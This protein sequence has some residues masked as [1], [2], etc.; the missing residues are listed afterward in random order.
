MKNKIIFSVGKKAVW[1]SIILVL[2]CAMVLGCAIFSAK[3]NCADAYTLSYLESGSVNRIGNL[4]NSEDKVFNRIALNQLAQSVGYSDVKEML[5]AVTESET[6]AKS[7]GIK[8]AADFGDTTVK[9]GSFNSLRDGSEIELEW[10]PVFLSQSNVDADKDGSDD[11]ILT[12]WLTNTATNNYGAGSNPGD[13]YQESSIYNYTYSYVYKNLVSYHGHP[14]VYAAG[15]SYAASYIRNYILN[16]GNSYGT[17]PNDYTMKPPTYSRDQ[18]CKFTMLTSG[19]LSSYIV[20]PSQVTWQLAENTV[21]NDYSYKYTNASAGG[22]IHTFF[23]TD[24]IE[25][26]IWLPSVAEVSVKTTAKYNLWQVNEN[27]RLGGNTPINIHAWLRSAYIPNYNTSYTSCYTTSGNYAFFY[28]NSLCVR[29]ALHLN[30]TAA[31]ANAASLVDKPEDVSVEYTGEKQDLSTLPELPDWAK[32]NKIE[33]DYLGQSIIDAKSYSI[34]ASITQDALDAAN[35][36]GDILKFRGSPDEEKGEDNY[37]RFFNFVVTKK[38]IELNLSLDDNRRPKIDFDTGQIFSGDT[39]ENTRA[40]IIKLRYSSQDATQDY[41]ENAPTAVGKYTA[42]AYVENDG[43]NYELKQE[44]TIDFEIKPKDVVKPTLETVEQVYDGDWLEFTLSG[45]SDDVVITAVRNTATSQTDGDPVI[46][47]ATVKAKRTGTY[48]ITVALADDGEASQWAGTTSKESYTIVFTVTPK[49]LN[50]SFESSI[51]AWSWENGKGGN[52]TVTEDSLSSDDVSLS[53]HYYLSTNPSNKITVSS[54]FDTSSLGIGVYYICAT[55]DSS[56]GNNANY[57]LTGNLVS[58]EFKVTEVNADISA[59]TWYYRQGDIQ[60]PATATNGIVHVTYTGEEYN[61]FVDDADFATQGVKIDTAFGASGYQNVKGINAMTSSRTATVRIV[62]LPG[63]K[64]SSGTYREFTLV[65]QIDK[66]DYDLSEVSWSAKE[67][68]YNGKSQTVTLVGLPTGLSVSRYIYSPSSTVGVG[69]YTASVGSFANAN[70]NYNTPSVD[71]FQS[72]NWSIVPIK[73]YISWD[74]DKNSDGEGSVYFVPVLHT[75]NDKVEYTYY[76]DANGKPSD[77]QISLADIVVDET[78]Q[79][80]YWVKVELKSA[81]SNFYQLVDDTGN[82]PQYY[83]TFPVGD[84]KTPVSVSLKSS[85]VTYN[86]AQQPVS[87]IISNIMIQESDFDIEYSS[88]S[89]NTFVATAPSNAGSYIVRI[90]LNQ[91]DY[92]LKGQKQ[93]NYQIDKADFDLSSVVWVYSGTDGSSGDYDEPFKYNKVTYTLTLSGLPSGVSVPSGAYGGNSGVDSKVYTASVS[94]L[95]YDK[96]NFNIIDL[97]QLDL[98]WEIEKMQITVIWTEK[99]ETSGSN[100]FEVWT[101]ES[102]QDYISAYYRWEQWD[103]SAPVAGATALTYDQVVASFDEAVSAKFVCYVLLK[104]SDNYAVSGLSFKEFEI[105]GNKTAVTV[106]LEVTDK[107]YDGLAFEPSVSTKIQ[108]G[109]EIYAQFEFA[110]YDENGD[111]LDCVPVNAGRYSVHITLTGSYAEDYVISG[112]SA[113][114]FTI[115]KAQ[116]DISDL[117]WSDGVNEYLFDET[118][119]FIYSGDTYALS[120]VGTS[121]IKDFEVTLSGDTNGKSARSYEIIIDVKENPNYEDC[122]LSDRFVWTIAPLAVDFAGTEWNYDSPFI[123]ARNADGAIEQNVGLTFPQGLPQEILD[124]LTALNLYG[125][126]YYATEVGRYEATANLTVLNTYVENG[127]D[128]NN[129][130]IAWADIGKLTWSIDS[131]DFDMPV[132]DGSWTVFDGD[133]H[134]L[135]VACGLPEG[136]QYYLDISVNIT[137]PD[138]A[139]QEYAGVD[140]IEWLGYDAGGYE[141]IFKVKDGINVNN[142][143]NVWIGDD[144]T[145]SVL[146]SVSQRVVTVSGWRGVGT[147]AQAQFSDE[148]VLSQW[149]TYV[150]Y[151][152][153]SQV[154]VVDPSTG[155]FAPGKYTRTVEPTS[156]NIKIQ[157][158]G[159]HAVTFTVDESGEETGG[160]L[161]PTPDDKPQITLDWDTSKNPP[162]LK[163]PDEYKDDLHPEYEYFDKDGNVIKLEDMVGGETYTVKAKLPADELDKF[164]IVDKNG[165]SVDFEELETIKF[166]KSPASIITPPPSSSSSLDEIIEKLKELP[167]WQLIASIISII[168]III[169]LSKTSGYESKRKKYNKKSDKLE[170]IYAVAPFLG[171][172]MSGWTAIACTLMGLA[173]AS[174]VIMLIVKIRC[175]KAEESYEDCLADFER[176]KKDEEK[177]SMRMMFMGM[178]GMSGGNIAYGIHDEL[179]QKL[180]EKTANNEETISQIV[181]NLEELIA[182]FLERDEIQQVAAAHIV[183]KVVEVPVEVEKIVEKEVPVEVE[184]IIEKEVRVEVPVEKVVEK[185]V[186][187]EVKVEA[188]AP[189]KPKA[190]KAPRLTLDEAYALL[191]KEQKKYFDGLRD[192]ALTKYKCKEKKSTYFVVY[193]QTSTNPLLKLTIKKDTTVALL[194]MEDEYMKDIRRD[195]TGD[196]TKV[197]VKETEVIVSDAQAFETAKKMVDLRDDQIERYQELLREQRAMKKK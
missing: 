169:F 126:T 87:L 124:A 130:N 57:A 63:F 2:L 40:P 59:V 135:V 117:R 10:I 138:G 93:F 127:F 54:P 156:Q 197:R 163:I 47:G 39:M 9:L 99:S 175:N 81:Y 181:K 164:N 119:S 74:Y 97:T 25:D 61:F 118:I 149:Y 34:K 137:L 184:K 160:E 173:V 26:K 56:Y 153:D 73:I 179:V 115:S 113:F 150:V 166:T 102:S 62:A 30:L 86:G 7:E 147:K 120:L 148:D 161:D 183:E 78:E 155:K 151:D 72:Y 55:L 71:A 58:Q 104:D 69:D 132:Y 44:Y 111:S 158:S 174:F 194:K 28:T 141:I 125:G 189:A 32:S 110:Y 103:G 76:T 1:L 90:T 77:T 51:G 94:D 4:Y 172:A 36:E 5:R 165:D 105:G 136:W 80:Y 8:T 16:G 21:F 114:E 75:D 20:A 167:L 12:L 139:K 89:G 142:D 116:Y 53:L 38:K 193:G 177:E 178:Q 6:D 170:T 67:L 42:T 13:S 3:G 140:G 182:K 162:E 14:N 49:T 66:A 121:D 176:R 129:F 112:E 168:L 131:R 15:N 143:Y 65:W 195:A 29:P 43:C 106:E 23:P 188:A 145:Q 108:D 96:D 31:V 180:L 95:V 133:S 68:P 154:A 50:V 79:V 101:A 157:F 91:D 100:K 190:E 122:G 192:Y 60:A 70:A 19:A 98:Q 82:D 64:F 144:D 152:A 171:I 83:A 46:N 37:T 128:I 185:V 48:T 17:F 24:W 33:I 41:G 88:D 18:L 123:Y 107:V 146:V 27:Q 159:A 85:S 134:D 92:A 45:V 191:S 196:G 84:N 22:D 35:A 52:I 11:V 186:E 187:K 109:S